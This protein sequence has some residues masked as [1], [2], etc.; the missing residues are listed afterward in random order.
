MLRFS[1]FVFPKVR[2]GDS[3]VGPVTPANKTIS[4]NCECSVPKTYDNN[5]M[6]VGDP[7]M[8][9]CSLLGRYVTS[10]KLGTPQGQNG[11][12][13]RLKF[14]TKVSITVRFMICVLVFFSKQ[15][16]F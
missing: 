10:Q 13:M 9:E 16:V 3:D 8:Y 14:I 7:H 5:T 2:A 6:D 15:T 4:V 11:I 12:S 1:L